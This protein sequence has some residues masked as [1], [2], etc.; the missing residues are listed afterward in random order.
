[1]TKFVIKH[2]NGKYV[3]RS[4][5]DYT[6]DILEAKLYSDYES[7]DSARAKVS[8]ALKEIVVEIEI[9]IKEKV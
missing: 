9:T 1:M 5:S 2:S 6:S 4:E 8:D 3:K 7:A